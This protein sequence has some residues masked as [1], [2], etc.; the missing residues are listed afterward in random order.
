MKKDKFIIT[1]HLDQREELNKCG[2]EEIP[3]SIPNYYIFLNN[4]SLKFSNNIDISKISYS[5]KF[6][7]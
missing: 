1:K 5:N 3:S 2:Y 7:I 4:L 6:F